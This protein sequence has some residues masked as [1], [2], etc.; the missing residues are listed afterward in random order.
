M[1]TNPRREGTASVE[2][3]LNATRAMLGAY[4]DDTMEI[5]QII[6]TKEELEGLRDAAPEERPVEWVAFW[7]ERDPNKDTPENEALEQILSRVRYVQKNYSRVGEGWRTD[8][9]RV[10]IKFGAPD[11]VDR[12]S[13]ENNQGE[14]E[15]WRYYSRNRTFV[16]Y[17]MFGMGDYKLVEGEPF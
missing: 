15:V 12:Q 2:F 5:L 16:F 11:R 10:Y 7:K 4:F 8:R 1:A 6:A 14:Y 13:D 17:D 3:H 9:G